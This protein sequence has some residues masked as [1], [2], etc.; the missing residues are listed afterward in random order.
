MAKRLQI[1]MLYFFTLEKRRYK[2][3]CCLSRE[4]LTAHASTFQH[5]AY[6][7][8]LLV[9]HF[10]VAKFSLEM[11]ANFLSAFSAVRKGRKICY[12]SHRRPLTSKTAATR[13]SSV[14]DAAVTAA[15][16]APSIPQSC[17]TDGRTCLNDDH[18]MQTFSILLMFRNAAGFTAGLWLTPYK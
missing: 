11:W 5:T 15:T 17:H 14:I 4:S 16:A 18:I 7:Q 6:V 9:K 2:S 10:I 12:N 13:Q 8:L 1:S 3:R